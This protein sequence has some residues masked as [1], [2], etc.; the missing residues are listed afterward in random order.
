[1]T[2]LHKKGFSLLELILVLGVGAMISF[3]KFQDMRI[4]Q[5]QV[6]ANAVGQQIKQVGEAVNGYINIRY[7]KIALLSNYIVESWD[8]IRGPIIQSFVPTS[9]FGRELPIQ[10]GD[11]VV[12]HCVYYGDV[13]LAL[14]SRLAIKSVVSDISEKAVE[15]TRLKATNPALRLD[16]VMKGLD[17]KSEGAEQ[18]DLVARVRESFNKEAK[19]LNGREIKYLVGDSCYLGVPTDSVD[20]AFSYEPLLIQN[21]PYLNHNNNIYYL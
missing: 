14:A 11:S 4:E 5:E 9:E 18:Q 6:L 1:M 19:I 3:I 17:V 13:F 16:L 15:I 12:F 10:D 7:D 20:W 2:I 21:L 8:S